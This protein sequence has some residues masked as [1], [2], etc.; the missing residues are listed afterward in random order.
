ML[1]DPM[2]NGT[3]YPGGKLLMDDTYSAAGSYEEP[4]AVVP[5]SLSGSATF[6]IISPSSAVA[7]EYAEGGA[8]RGQRRADPAAGSHQVRR[9]LQRQLVLLRRHRRGALHRSSFKCST[10]REKREWTVKRE[11]TEE[12]AASWADGWTGFDLHGCDVSGHNFEEG[13][14]LRN[15][16][17]MREARL[18]DCSLVRAK[19]SG[20]LCDCVFDESD[21]SGADFT[22][23]K[24]DCA[25]FVGCNLENTDFTGCTIVEVNLRK[26]KMVQ[27]K[28]NKA[29]AFRPYASTT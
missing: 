10:Q 24:L 13:T 4:D 29:E 16:A 2:N 15:V 28:V 9:A 3:A 5:D 26:S 1:E 12:E 22:G 6:A 8:R 19:F 7:Y 20:D 18:R 21:L 11:Q 27:T 17:G 14:D 25:S 23:S